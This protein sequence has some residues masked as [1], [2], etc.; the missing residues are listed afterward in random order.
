MLHTYTEDS[1]PEAVLTHIQKQ[2]HIHIHPQ[3][4]TTRLWGAG[5][6][7]LQYSTSVLKGKGPPG[8]SDIIDFP[9]KENS[10]S[11]N[12]KQVNYT[13]FTAALFATS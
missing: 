10:K 8:E 12:S 13:N 6:A 9:G 1:M 11:K 7:L 2:T 4:G 5:W 3:P